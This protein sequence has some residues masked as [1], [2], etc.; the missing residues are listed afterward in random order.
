MQIL[1]EAGM[2]PQVISYLSSAGPVF[3]EAIARSHHLA[4]V[5]FNRSVP[6]FKFYTINA[7][8]TA[9][10]KIS[11]SL[12][13]LEARDGAVFMS[14]VIG[15]KGF[16]RIKSYIDYD[17]TGVD[18]AEIVF[19]GKYDDSKGYFV[20]PT[21]SEVTNHNSTMMIKEI[22]GLVLKFYV[23]SVSNV[24]V[25][26]TSFKNATS[27]RLTGAVYSRANTSYTKHKIFFG[28]MNKPQSRWAPL[29]SEA[30]LTLNNQRSQCSSTQMA[31]SVFR[32]VEF[33]IC[34]SRH[35]SAMSICCI[36]LVCAN[37]KYKIAAKT[38]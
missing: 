19:G 18:G 24:N 4:A 25:L 35:V 34:I 31:I 36:M 3:G 10:I 23:Y 16:A 33:C 30:V 32:V 17:K 6:T 27:Y 7:F 13:L 20:E 37:G 22:F 28:M 29:H 21:I 2:P 8:P 12:N 15:A 14:A 9:W 11:A 26:F 5:N 1:E 38:S